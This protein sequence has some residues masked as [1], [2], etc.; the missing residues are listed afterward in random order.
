MLTFFYIKVGNTSERSGA[1]V[2]VGLGF[3]LPGAV[4]DGDEVLAFD[5]SCCNL[6]HTGLPMEDRANDDARQNQDNSYNQNNLFH[7]H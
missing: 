5:L 2:D 6:R 7:A 4:D 3:D 1:D